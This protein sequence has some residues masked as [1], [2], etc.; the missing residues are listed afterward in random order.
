M[1]YKKRLLQ[2]HLLKLSKRFPA[3]WI[4]GPRQSG[5]TTLSKTTFKDFIYLSFEDLDNRNY[6]QNDPRGFLRQFPGTLIL[7]EVQKCPDILP[8]LQ[9]HMDKVGKNGQFI[10]TGSHQFQLSRSIS[11]SLAGRVAVV[12]LLPF[13]LSEL[14]N[15]PQQAVH[16]AAEKGSKGIPIRHTIE[17]TLFKGMYPAVH[18]R[19]ASPTDWYASYYATYIERDIKEMAS[20]QSLRVFDTFV[21][22]CAAR[23][24]CLMNY[25][26]ISNESGVSVPTIKAW[27][28]MLEASG[29]ITL[30]PPYFKNYSKRLIKA[31][32]LYFLD[33]GLLCYLLRIKDFRQLITHPLKGAV[34]ET[35]IVSEIIKSFQHNK[36]E[37]PLYYWRDH[38]G[39]EIDLL[40]DLGPSQWP[41][42]IKSAE[43]VNSSF[44]KTINWWLA[45]PE[46]PAEY[47][48][49]IYGGKEDQDRKPINI[50]SWRTVV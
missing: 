13:S 31:P 23:S 11:Q 36:T 19:G 41:V 20:I 4:T 47:G 14:F 5:K 9:T 25:S 12:T 26:E 44:F 7:D 42:E 48:T 30:I 43:T 35:L 1:K 15:L 38:K 8:Y 22:L 10:L 40:I 46:N 24:G 27:V 50:R 17:K 21:R 37:P 32:K 16:K 39:R 33:S 28:S 34:F 6:A 29:I 49:I 45:L 3:V 2:T 18:D